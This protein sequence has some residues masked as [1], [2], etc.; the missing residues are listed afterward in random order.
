MGGSESGLLEL[1]VRGELDGSNM[2][3]IEKCAIDDN[4]A[5]YSKV[6]LPRGRQFEPDS[7]AALGY[8][9]FLNHLFGGRVGFVVHASDFRVC[10][11]LR[12]RV[13]VGCGRTMPV[14]VVLGEV[15]AG[16]GEGRDRPGTAGGHP[17]QLEAGEFNHERVEPAGLANR[18]EH[19]R[20]NVA[21]SGG[22]QTRGIQ[23]VRRQLH[24]RCL[25]VGTSHQDPLGY[26]YFV[27]H[28]P[29]EFNIPPDAYVAGRGPSD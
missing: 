1:S 10:V 4:V 18:V 26:P 19:R 17:V 7:T 27:T 21:D 8:L 13:T 20:S 15:E 25:A 6:A 23:N 2:S 5:D 28:A 22:A 29:G 24:G 9:G 3:I 14:V 12:F 16:R 11:Y